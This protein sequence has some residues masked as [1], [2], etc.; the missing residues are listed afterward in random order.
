M[1]LQ[2]TM[3][4]TRR[5]CI[6]LPA[7]VSG[8]L[9]RVKTVSFFCDCLYLVTGVRGSWQTPLLTFHCYDAKWF[10]GHFSAPWHTRNAVVHIIFKEERQIIFQGGVG[11]RTLGDESV[12]VLNL[13]LFLQSFGWW[14]TQANLRSNK[15]DSPSQKKK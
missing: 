8:P 15:N 9:S 7:D 6:P 14:C 13:Y 4:L 5:F 2:V 10:W 1:P 12:Y 11:I 3:G